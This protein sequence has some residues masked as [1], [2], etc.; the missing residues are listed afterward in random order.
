[1]FSSLK[2][3]KL[4]KSIYLNSQPVRKCSSLSKT[5][6]KVVKVA[7]NKWSILFGASFAV[8]GIWYLQADNQKKRRV[9]VTV[10][11][12]GRFLRYYKLSFYSWKS[13][14]IKILFQDPL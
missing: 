14:K 6:V 3:I 2:T 9:R 1:M 10:Q 8:P 11:G 4:F 12:I 7:K 13:S 5:N